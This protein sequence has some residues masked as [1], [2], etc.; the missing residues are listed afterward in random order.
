MRWSSSLPAYEPYARELA[1]EKGLEERTSFNVVDLLEEP[2]A[3]SRRTSVA[4]QPCRLLLARRRRARATAGRLAR[5]ALHPELS[6]R[7]GG[8][9]RG[10]A[11]YERRSSGSCAARIAVYVHSPG[12]SLVRCRE[13]GGL[14]VVRGRPSGRLGVRSRCDVPREQARAVPAAVGAA[15]D[16]ASFP[17]TSSSS[18]TGSSSVSASTRATSSGSSTRTTTEC[19][20]SARARGSPRCSPVWRTDGWT[21]LVEGG[22]RFRLVGAEHHRPE[23]PPGEVSPSRSRC[24]EQVLRAGIDPTG[25]RPLRRLHGSREATSTCP[26]RRIQR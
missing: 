12:V 14:H 17:C 15:A 18:G 24:E 1:R 26:P 16:R 8:A 5:R 9:G 21:S 11:C 19:A 20:T 22:D 10:I 13:A 3:V 6:A 7:R 2:A 25:A 4:P 23:L